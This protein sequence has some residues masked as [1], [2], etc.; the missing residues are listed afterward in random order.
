MATFDLANQPV[1]ETVGLVAAHLNKVTTANDTKPGKHNLTRFHARTKPSID[2]LGYANRIMKYAPCGNECF[3]AVLIYLERMEDPSR[4]FLSGGFGSN[5]SKERGLI[6]AMPVKGGCAATLASSDVLVDSYN[7]HR[8]MITGI[9]VAVKFHSDVFFTNLHYA[10]VGGLPVHELNELEMEFLLS[11]GFNLTISIEEFQYVGDKLLEA[12][13]A[14]LSIPPSPTLSRP[15]SNSPLVKEITPSSSD[16]AA[17]PVDKDPTPIDHEGKTTAA[18]PAETVPLENGS[19]KAMKYEHSAGSQTT[20]SSLIPSAQCYSSPPPCLEPR[21]V[22]DSFRSSAHPF[23][24]R[25][26]LCSHKSASMP[27]PHDIMISSDGQTVLARITRSPPPTSHRLFSPYSRPSLNRHHS[28]DYPPTHTAS[29][30]ATVPYCS[31]LYTPPLPPTYRSPPYSPPAMRIHV[32]PAG[33]LSL[34]ALRACTMRRRAAREAQGLLPGSQ[35]LQSPP[36]ESPS[37]CR[38]CSDNTSSDEE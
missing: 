32:R 10:R 22:S 3:L 26:S 11:S 36:E 6:S 13:S 34:P 21:Y 15:R 30:G 23:D 14:P 28:L 25:E 4:R 12:A 38:P 5:G 20:Q 33:A 31:T 16:A 27:R 24:V 7:V 29:H 8:L 9:M 17:R 37:V 19:R 2:I 35:Q 1:Q 18:R